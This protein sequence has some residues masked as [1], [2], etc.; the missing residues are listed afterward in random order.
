MSGM[1]W[2]TRPYRVLRESASAT[3]D[4][5]IVSDVSF[6]FFCAILPKHRTAWGDE[7]EDF[8]SAANVGH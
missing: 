4:R 7:W 1:H 8:E 6:M 5:T 3:S 2:L